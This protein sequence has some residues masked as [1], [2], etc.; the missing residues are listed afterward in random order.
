MLTGLFQVVN[1]ETTQ[2]KR[3]QPLFADTAP[4]A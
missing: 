4:P 2:D 3:P 1:R